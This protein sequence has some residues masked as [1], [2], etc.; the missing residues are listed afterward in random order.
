[1]REG[2][3][4]AVAIKLK[5]PVFESQTKNK[6]GNSDI[7]PWIMQE[8]KRGIDD[9]LRRNPVAAKALQDKIA[10]NERLRTELN[11]VKK[12]AK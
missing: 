1:M 4:A 6:L 8:M 2:I 10:A 11:I 3:A 7:K 5:D 9:F 12:E